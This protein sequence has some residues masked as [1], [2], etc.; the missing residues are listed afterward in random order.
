[1]VAWLSDGQ[2]QEETKQGPKV[3]LLRQE[4]FAL[5]P[6]MLWKHLSASP[7]WT[8]WFTV[9]LGQKRIDSGAWD[10]G[11]THIPIEDTAVF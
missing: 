1:M 9:R 6:P 3:S 7:N 5:L 4:P 10:V 11:L 8:R 2:C